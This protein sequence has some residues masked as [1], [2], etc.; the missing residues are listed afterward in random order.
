[1]KLSDCTAALVMPSSW[2]LAVAGLGRIHSA[3]L[4]A[5]GLDPERS[6]A[7]KW[8]RGHDV[9][10]AEVGVARVLDLDAAH[11]LLVLARGSRTCR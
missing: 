4:A 6:P 11:Q 8:S 2:V 7:S 3:L 5:G 1:M 9:A 10:L